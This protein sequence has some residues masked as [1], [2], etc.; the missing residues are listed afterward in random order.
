VGE[1]YLKKG[2]TAVYDHRLN[3]Q[4][5]FAVIGELLEKVSFPEGVVGFLVVRKGEEFNIGV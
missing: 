4:D 5:C 3:W 2:N 1:L